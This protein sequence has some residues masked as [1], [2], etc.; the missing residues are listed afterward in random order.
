MH[1][2]QV[3]RFHVLA[4][5]ASL[6][7]AAPSA[8][9]NLKAVDED[10]PWDMDAGG[11]AEDRATYILGTTG[12]VTLDLGYGPMVGINHPNNHLIITS[13]SSLLGTSG[14][15]GSGD[16]SNYNLVNVV[17]AGSS[18]IIEDRLDVGGDGS[19]NHL[20]VEDGAY[21]STSWAYVGLTEAAHHNSL[22]I[23]G[24]GSRMVVQS[25]MTLG[26]TG[27]NNTLHIG[28]GGALSVDGMLG[29]GG[30]D[31]GSDNAAFVYDRGSI[32]SVQQLGI[33]G[34]GTQRNSL[35]I[36]DA[37]LV[38]ISEYWS[39]DYALMIDPEGDSFLNFAGG[40]LAIEGDARDL[41]GDLISQG[42]FRF[43][44]EAAWTIGSADDFIFDYFANEADALAFT[45]YAGLAGYTIVTNMPGSP[46]PEPSTYAALAGCA[47]LG[48]AAFRRYRFNR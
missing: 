1:P 10:I 37:A 15:I 45:G 18:W 24:S 43:G 44:N 30:Y 25:G 28:Y 7:F 47:V 11:T 21:V 20:S 13:G 32:L 6:A 29:V 22:H 23:S 3:S 41:I 8:H 33:G 38:R 42:A 19:H 17:G 46:I 31:T 12:P 48:L 9:A 4:L 39:I 34:Y 40:F 27:T 36:Q 2:R 5:C 35:T 16:T 14:Y 26:S